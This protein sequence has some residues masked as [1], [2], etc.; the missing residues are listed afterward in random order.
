M[1]AG[2]EEKKRIK[3]QLWFLRP[4]FNKWIVL[5]KQVKKRVNTRHIF[6]DTSKAKTKITPVD[7]LLLGSRKMELIFCCRKNQSGKEFQTERFFLPYDKKGRTWKRSHVEKHH[8]SS[9]LF[10]THLYLTWGMLVL[11]CYFE[12][13]EEERFTRSYLG[14]SEHRKRKQLESGF[15][16]SFPWPRKAETWRWFVLK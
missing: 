16:S 5:Q 2:K 8:Q 12:P 10:H 9:R 3:N 11:N 1:V 13:E 15:S 4:I 6:Y 7:Y 14:F